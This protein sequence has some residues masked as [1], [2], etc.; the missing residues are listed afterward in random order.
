MDIQNFYDA[1]KVYALNTQG[2][3]TFT[4]GDVYTVWN[5][6]NM[7]YG[8]FNAALQY[9]EYREN[10]VAIHLTV[11]YG[12]KLANDSSNVYEAQTH[13]F[14]AIRNVVNHLKDAFELDGDE[15]TQIYPFWQRFADVLAGAYADITVF[16]PID[17]QCIDY[18]KE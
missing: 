6:L 10:V 9:V 18:D 1:I 14:R 17:E 13:G 4:I 2:V 7:K 8:A 16:V 11:Y 12:E 3:E 15:Y 5:S